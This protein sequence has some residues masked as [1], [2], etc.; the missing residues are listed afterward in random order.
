MFEKEET[1]CENGPTTEQSQRSEGATGH[2]TRPPQRQV[3]S[4]PLATVV[5]VPIN[6]ARFV[7]V[8]RSSLER[9]E[10]PVPTG[11]AA[12]LKRPSSPNSIALP[13]AKRNAL[14]DVTNQVCVC[15]CVCEREREGE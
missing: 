13:R 4:K 5:E 7:T 14:G 15:V 2:Q 3:K 11:A 1:R 9:G 8:Q 10:N 6:C 12:G